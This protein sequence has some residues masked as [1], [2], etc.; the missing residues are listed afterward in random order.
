M[1]NHARPSHARQ[2]GAAQPAPGA[3]ALL[4][5][6]SDWYWE[7][8]AE[9]RFTRVDVRS[10]AAA[11]QAL[12][13]RPHRQE[14][15]GNRH[16]D[17]RRLG[18]A[19]RH[20]RGARAVPRRA[21]VAHL[22]RRRAPLRQRQRRADVRRQGPLHRLPRHRPRRHQAEAH[23]AAPQAR[24]RGHAAPRRGG[25]RRRGAARRAAGGLRHAAP[26]TA[27]SCGRRTKPA[28]CCG[29]SRTGRRPAHRARSA[30]SRPRA[31]LTFRP[32]EGLVGTVWQSGEPIWVPDVAADPRALPHA[33]RRGD[34]PARRPCFSR[35]AP[36]GASPRVL[37]FTSRAHA[38]ARQAPVADARRDRHADRP[39]P[40]PRRGRARGARERSA[41]PRAHQPVV[42]LV[43]G[44]R[45]R[46]PLHAPR[47]PQ[48]RRR[49]PRAA[50][51]PD[52]PA[53]AGTPASKSKAAGTRTARCSR[54]ASRSTT[55]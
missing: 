39:V 51:A 55:C 29:A 32:G 10:D 24:P 13:A 15:L 20:A 46:V 9:L 8:D 3:P 21:D 49:R 50:A 47:G 7:Q 36:A 14:A 35:C 6:T 16:R 42:R 2:R 30:S 5:L 54:R 34:R 44:A 52:R 33:A 38:P 23:P 22:P 48:R 53:R 27:P 12:A 18:R 40:R 26:G 1:A 17:R 41:L 45:R 11:E 25:E 19:P 43:L 4:G 31:D 28:A 37:E